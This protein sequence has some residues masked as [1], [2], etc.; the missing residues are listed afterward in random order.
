MTP[1]DWA[2]AALPL[3]LVLASALPL[4]R[5]M[6]R[7]WSGDDVVL[8]PI[9]RPVERAIYALA[10]VETTTEQTWSGYAAAMLVFNGL[11][12]ITV[13]ALQLLQGGLPLN[14]QHFGAPPWH[15]ALNTAISFATNTNWQGYSGETTLSYF[16][17][18][19][20]LTVQNFVSAASGMA[21][22]PAVARGFQRK[23]S[24]TI[25]CFTV[26]M[27]RA[28]LYV[29]LPMSL[30]FALFLVS[31]GVIQTFAPYAVAHTLDGVQQ[32]IALG[33]VASQEA[34]KMLG[35]NGGGFFNANSAHPFE[36]PNPLTNLAEL[37]S[38]LV[39]SA[40]LCEAFGRL[41]LDARQGRALLA[42][43][44]AILVPLLIVACLA[45][46]G[47]WEGK[48][49]R[50][51]PTMSAVWAVFT[52][53]ASNGSVNAMHDSFTPLGGLIP[54]WLMLLGEV[55]F[56]GVGS[57]LYGMIAFA[58]V[59]VFVAGLMVGRTP[60]YLGKKIAGVRDADGVD[61]DPRAGVR[62]PA[63][64]CPRGRHR[65]GP[66]W[67]AE[68][69][70]PRVLRG[71]V[72]LRVRLQQQRQRVRRPHREHYVLRSRAR[73]RDAHRSVPREGR[74]ARGRRG[75]GCQEARPA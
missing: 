24:S 9:L 32:T 49:V 41:V 43:M 33:P 57:G 25:G 66:R 70:R 27:T 62:R 42:A 28:T 11:G 58:L 64:R 22:V 54:M 44:T 8:S 21:L 4:G 67:R 26:D 10:G 38:I 31:Q 18:M 20:G 35:T 37:V 29:L 65:R 73:R 16:T 63:G 50:F 59:A 6:A 1:I 7:V 30:L 19:T 52:T 15:L 2:A 39:I 72:R 45:E 34:I 17:Q 60:E 68:P 46:A 36:N 74:A 14:P 47:N 53:A 56:G 13:F 51:G 75:A 55:V 3:I 23:E 12:L 40:A 48:E 61:R 71:A 5:Y 69:R